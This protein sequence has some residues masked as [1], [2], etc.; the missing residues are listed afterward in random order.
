MPKLSL[1][2]LF[3]VRDDP[4]PSGDSLYFTLFCVELL[5]SGILLDHIGKSP[6]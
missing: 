3:R 1:P 6:A 5:V 2:V 4:I